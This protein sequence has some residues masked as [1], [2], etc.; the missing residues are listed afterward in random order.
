MTHTERE[1]RDGQLGGSGLDEGTGP[2]ARRRR[3]TRWPDGCAK[4]TR[5]PGTCTRTSRW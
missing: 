3:P 5:W 4:V 1:W 2:A